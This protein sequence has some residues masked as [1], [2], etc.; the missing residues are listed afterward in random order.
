MSASLTAVG[1]AGVCAVSFGG[2]Y[3]AGTLTRPDQAAP[4]PAPAPVAA[5]A[6]A[7]ITDLGRAPELPG[8][9]VTVV[10]KR[11]TTPKAATPVAATAVAARSTPV[12]RPAP[13]PVATVPVS[14][15]APAPSTPAV[16][17]QSTPKPKA[18][19]STSVA[20]FDDGG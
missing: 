8:L 16:Q 15:P 7:A 20:F 18:P 6:Q 13:R 4:A 17:R 14:R 3:A 12:V 1:I 10:H 2:A 5:P 19:A 9:R 11:R